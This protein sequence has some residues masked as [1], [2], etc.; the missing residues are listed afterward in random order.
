MNVTWRRKKKRARKLFSKSP[1]VAMGYALVGGN[2]IGE[3]PIFQT[4]YTK[5]SL[6]NTTHGHIISQSRHTG[7]LGIGGEMRQ[8]RF[9]PMIW[10]RL[11]VQAREQP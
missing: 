2:K 11:P 5:R 3:S 4:R 6:E 1:T 10:S 9:G 8:S 7:P